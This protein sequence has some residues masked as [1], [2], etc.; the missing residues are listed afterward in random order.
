MEQLPTH[1]KVG[2]K[3]IIFKQAIIF[4]FGTSKRIIFKNQTITIKKR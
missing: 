1:R 4:Q 2:D 3:L